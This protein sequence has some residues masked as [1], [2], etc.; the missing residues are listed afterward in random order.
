MPEWVKYRD[1]SSK[2]RKEREKNGLP[3]L[4]KPDVPWYVFRQKAAKRLAARHRRR[5]LV[6]PDSEL[7]QQEFARLVVY[8]ERKELAKRSRKMG[9]VVRAR[10]ASS[11]V[12]SKILTHAGEGW[13]LGGKMAL[14]IGDSSIS[15][16]EM[17]WV[18][19]SNKHISEQDLDKVGISKR[20]IMFRSD[21]KYAN[22]MTMSMKI[23][24]PNK[25]KNFSVR[26]VLDAIL[27][28]EKATRAHSTWLD[29]KIDRTHTVFNGIY[30]PNG[31]DIIASNCTVVIAWVEPS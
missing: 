4:K 26:D 24:A 21:L 6:T 17:D 2:R 15:L 20:S 11:L 3:P 27:E 1:A 31:G 25:K 19:A 30:P 23:D 12:R 13:F 14:N 29:E 22:N 16:S 18:D 8:E 28:F 7:S 10:T 5:E 9:S